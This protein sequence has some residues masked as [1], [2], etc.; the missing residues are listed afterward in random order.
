MKIKLIFA[1]LLMSVMGSAAAA[2]ENN[3]KFNGTLVALPCTIPDSDRTIKVNMATTNAHDLYLNQAMPRKTFTVHLEDCDPTIKDKISI[4]FSG[5]EDAA[6]PGYLALDSGQSTASGVAIGLESSSSEQI[7][8][9]QETSAYSILVGNNELSFRA[10]IAGEPDAIR[11]RTIV[12]G[13]FSATAIIT[14]NY[15]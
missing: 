15:S 12:V 9:N 2:T 11:N 4:T 3:V 14:L 5:A 6:L 13:S 1:A 8:V 7:K 10:Y